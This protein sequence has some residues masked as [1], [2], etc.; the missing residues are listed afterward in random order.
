[1]NCAANRCISLVLK[2][3]MTQISDESKKIMRRRS[4]LPG[5]QATVWVSTGHTAKNNASRNAGVSGILIRF[6]KMKSR[7]T[8]M[9]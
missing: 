9:R 5:I 3:S 4:F 1:M 2:Y 8:L 6:R 7:H